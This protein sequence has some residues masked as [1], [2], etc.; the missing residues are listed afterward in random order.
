MQTATY[1]TEFEH[2]TPSNSALR[3]KRTSIP[4]RFIYDALVHILTVTAPH[5]GYFLSC[6]GQADVSFH[7]VGEP[8]AWFQAPKPLSVHRMS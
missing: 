8:V 4:R 5:M 1:P 6:T 7:Q 3:S 2:Q